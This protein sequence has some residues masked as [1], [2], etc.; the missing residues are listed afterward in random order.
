MLPDLHVGNMHHISIL[1]FGLHHHGG[2]PSAA[3]VILV[4]D[5]SRLL[6]VCVRVRLQPPAQKTTYMR[7]GQKIFGSKQHICLLVTQ[8]N[9]DS[10]DGQKHDEVTAL[11]NNY[12]A[13]RPPLELW[14][15]MMKSSRKECSLVWRCRG[16][17]PSRA[18]RMVGE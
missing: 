14:T 1:V 4:Q 9:V 17:F 6:G 12:L 16:R 10:F 11:R 18:S 3:Y 5:E 13:R 8:K 2:W 15:H 7:V